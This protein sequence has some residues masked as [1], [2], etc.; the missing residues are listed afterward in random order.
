M[1]YICIIQS[2]TLKLFSLSY[3]YNSHIRIL[4]AYYRFQFDQF[5]NSNFVEYA[6]HLITLHYLYNFILV[7][8]I[9]HHN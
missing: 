1:E 4:N 8:Q 7:C 3:I 9:C 2:S 5:Y 6:L